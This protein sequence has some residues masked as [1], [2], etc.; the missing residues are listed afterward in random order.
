MNNL[1]V[2]YGALGRHTDALVMREKVLEFRRRVLPEDH[3]NIGD[4]D[5]FI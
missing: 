4:V 3:P 1:A 5:V 2:T